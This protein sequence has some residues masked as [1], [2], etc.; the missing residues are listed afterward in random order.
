[1][2]RELWIVGGI[3]LS[4]VGF[5]ILLAVLQ[6]LLPNA[7]ELHIFYLIAYWLV[8]SFI[9]ATKTKYAMM[10]GFSPMG[11]FIKYRSREERVPWRRIASIEEKGGFS[12]HLVI[13][14]KNDE[15]IDLKDID[16][17]LQRGIKK[18]YDRFAASRKLSLS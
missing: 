3:G 2:K 5:P 8:P 12:K 17:R 9:Y 1:M 11:V 13:T 16:K 18:S 4:L 6:L 7:W 14:K 10:V 15:V